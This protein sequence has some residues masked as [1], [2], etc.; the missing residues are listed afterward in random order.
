MRCRPDATPAVLLTCWA[1]GSWLRRSRTDQPWTRARAS[2]QAWPESTGKAGREDVS[3]AWGSPPTNDSLV[4][5]RRGFRHDVVPGRRLPVGL[6][7]DDVAVRV[8]RSR[9]KHSPASPA[10]VL[11]PADR[12]PVA[13]RPR[14]L[15]PSQHGA[16]S[17]ASHGAER[18]IDA[19]AIGTA[20]DELPGV[21]RLPVRRRPIGG[22]RT[23]V[24]TSGP[25]PQENEE[26][27]KPLH[28]ASLP[29]VTWMNPKTGLATASQPCPI[30]RTASAMSRVLLT[31]WAGGGWH[32]RSWSD[33]CGPVRARPHN[34]GREGRPHGGRNAVPPL[35]ISRM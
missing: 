22:R 8:I 6:R 30:K 35:P 19:L 32:R 13:V 7:V 1:A 12:L 16:P 26:C 3:T 10:V 4:V 34:R 9:G 5:L 24:S 29:H 27:Q 17:R 2:T 28:G 33:H 15:A 18:K 31:C 25:G 21:I 14:E 23:S 20:A 11:E